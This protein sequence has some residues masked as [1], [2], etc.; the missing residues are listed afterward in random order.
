M[1]STIQMLEHSLTKSKKFYV[2]L[3]KDMR[4]SSLEM[5]VFEIK[6]SYKIFNKNIYTQL[7]GNYF[8]NTY[9]IFEIMMCSQLNLNFRYY[10]LL[11]M[12]VF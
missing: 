3:T 5:F 10:I 12:T 11:M 6:L 4:F 2:N 7:L 9:Y 1:K 8:Q